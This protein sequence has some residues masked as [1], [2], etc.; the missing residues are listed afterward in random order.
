[1]SRCQVILGNLSLPTAALPSP[2][3]PRRT[4]QLS[5]SLKTSPILLTN[6]EENCNNCG[7]TFSPE[8]Q[9]NNGDEVKENEVSAH[10]KSKPLF[11]SSNPDDRAMFDQL[12]NL[13]STLK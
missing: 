10:K 7:N 3:I 13:Y 1:M 8:H 5:R 11:S 9:C 4:D 2:E 12:F 6:R